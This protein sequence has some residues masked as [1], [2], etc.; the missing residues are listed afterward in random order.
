VSTTGEDVAV[1]LAGLRGCMETSFARMEG[2][3]E[4]ISERVARTQADLRDQEIRIGLLEGRRWPLASVG[5]LAGAVSAIVAT[6]PFIM[7]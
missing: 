3:L 4:I 5:V 6:V 2:Q 7:R 1:E